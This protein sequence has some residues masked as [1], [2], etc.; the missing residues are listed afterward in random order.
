MGGGQLAGVRVLDFGIWRPVPS[1][2]ALLADLG[3]DVIKVE[4]PGGDPMRAFPGLFRE[5]ARHKRSVV[6]DLRTPG[7]RERALALAADADA[8]LE[9]FRPG[10]AERLGIG[11]EAVR[12][13][14]PAVVYCSVS[15]YGHV[16]ELAD[17]PGHDVNYQAFA[18]ALAPEGEDPPVASPLP[19]ADLAAGLVA[20]FAVCAALIG[21]RATGEGERI[22]IAM[23]DVIATWVGPPGVN[24]VADAPGASRGVGGYGTFRTADGR[25]VALGVIAEDHFWRCVCDALG[26]PELRGATFAERVARGAELNE[27]IARRIA[28]LP[29]ARVV[30]VL[31]EAGA[32]VAPVLSRDAMAA[33]D[34]FR[35]RGAIVEGPDGA[36]TAG[37]PARFMNRPARPPA[38]PPALG[39]HQQEGWMPR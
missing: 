26:L 28:T 24:R 19:V 16:G 32:P 11:Y 37:H 17:L 21:A 34:H 7:G 35:A 15:G 18:G 33:L 27:A 20:A 36:L 23:A 10:V 12:A 8:V 30:E 38:P 9:G 31:R 2:T 39:E 29:A 22:D 1:A 6:L 25:W 14:N 3:A 13:V 5:L 4:P